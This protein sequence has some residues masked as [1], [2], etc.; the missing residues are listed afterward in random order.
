MMHFAHGGGWGSN[1]FGHMGMRGFGGGIFGWIM[2]FLFAALIVTGIVYLIKNLNKNSNSGRRNDN[3]N[4]VGYKREDSAK[5]IARNR[6]AKGEIDKEEL[7]E[8]LSN[9][10]K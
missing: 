5:E 9:L 10:N 3:Y 2:M 7:N 8:I 1:G 4:Q 6:Y